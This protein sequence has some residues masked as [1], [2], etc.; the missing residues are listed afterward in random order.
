MFTLRWGYLPL[1]F[2]LAALLVGRLGALAAPHRNGA[3][4]LLAGGVLTLAVFVFGVRVL[5][6]M[7]L[8]TPVNLM[9]ALAIVVAL[10]SGASSV[11]RRRAL[12]LGWSQA[13]APE[14][15]GILGVAAF[16]LGTAGFAAYLLPIWQWDAVGYHLPYVNFVLQGK[17]FA[18]VPTGA[19]YIST[20]PHV[21]E[22]FFVAW[23]AMLPDD[24]LVDLA[25]VPFGFL[26]AVAVCALA[27]QFGAKPA[28]AVAA[29][30]L[31]VTLPAVVLQM[32]TN[33]I[34]V[35]V[36]ALLLASVAFV[37]APVSV[38]SVLLSGVALGLF[39]GTKPNAPVATSILFAVM[40]V[41][42]RSHPKALGLAAL[43]IVVLGGES[44]LLNLAQHG[45]PV[46]PVSVNIGPWRLPGETPMQALLDSGA[47]APRVHGPLLL[48]MV[49]SWTALAATP[50]FDMRYGGLG[51]VF[52]LALPLAVVHAVRVR[53]WL[54][55]PLALAT[56]AS[57][58]PAVPRYVLAFPGLIF[59]IAAAAVASVRTPAIRLGGAAT[60]AAAFACLAQAIPGL[61]G[62]GP[63]LLSYVAMTEGERERAVGPDGEPTMFLSA[64]QYLKPGERTAFGAAFELPYFAWPS[65]LSRT[66]VWVAD[67]EQSAERLLRDTSVRIV[68]M[69]DQSHFATAA[70]AHPS[71]FRPLFH[72]KSVPCTAFLR[73]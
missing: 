72:C 66:A 24:R 28:H 41:R 73:L 17:G 12:R 15:W 18:E 19:P 65:D 36:A 22:M 32:P 25:Q 29:G 39:L 52:L 33:Y 44:Y 63:P 62:E 56:L 59:A 58:D 53:A 5:G 45:N 35:A 64:H 43:T 10:A 13:A 60:A 7:G 42:S 34:D 68:I 37:A 1:A 69:D 67:D 3:E 48:R 46:W 20:Y 2:A 27:R 70:G 8:V 14:T 49:R 38:S 31:F 54:L 4:R 40:V 30:A 50:A 9:F 11:A 23:R 57:P 16:A 61:S 47:G 26:G 6:Q 21:V 55:V 71:L 51:A